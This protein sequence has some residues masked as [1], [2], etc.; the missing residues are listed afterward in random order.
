MHYSEDER[1]QLRDGH[2]SISVSQK[3]DVC[4]P[5][6]ATLR[7][8]LM[9]YCALLFAW[10]SVTCRRDSNTLSLL[11]DEYMMLSLSNRKRAIES[12]LR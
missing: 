11:Y 2:M 10:Y 6:M 12:C 9:G 3:C 1:V 5:W 7:N 4:T 8:V